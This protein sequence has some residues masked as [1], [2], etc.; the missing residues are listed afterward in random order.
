MYRKCYILLSSVRLYWKK[1]RGRKPYKEIKK[2]YC[3][4]GGYSGPYFNVEI[5]LD[6]KQVIHETV[7][8]GTNNIELV[9]NIITDKDLKWFLSQLYQR[10]F[11]NW[12]EEYFMPILDGTSWSVRI[13]YGLHCE[14]KTGSNA[15][16]D[17][18]TKFT[19]AVAKLSSSDFY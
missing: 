3:E 13:E 2:I 7:N 16:P 17:K 9:Q 19:K 18:W 12:A 15:F 14:I 5:N 4:A 10:D 6:N 11:V 1:F 8:P